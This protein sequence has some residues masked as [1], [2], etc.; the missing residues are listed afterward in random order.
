VTPAD[1]SG[2]QRLLS[3]HVKRCRDPV[4]STR[5]TWKNSSGTSWRTTA[6]YERDDE[7]S[8]DEEIEDVGDVID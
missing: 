6:R 4:C 2:T 7:A 3:D 8:S 5:T 1:G